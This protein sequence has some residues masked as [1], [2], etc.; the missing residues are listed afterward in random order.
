[1]RYLAR[2]LQL[3]GLLEMGF[4]LFTGVL[5]DLSAG[6]GGLVVNLRHALIGG[7]LF[8]AGWL[9]QKSQRVR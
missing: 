4:G 9:I 8:L 6:E 2:F 1:M 3:I 7:A 5:Q